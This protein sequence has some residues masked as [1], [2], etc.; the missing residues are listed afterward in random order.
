MGQERRKN[1]TPQFEPKDAVR[2]LLRHH[3]II[4]AFVGVFLLGA[5]IEH[6]LF[7][8]FRARAT[9]YIDRSDT[10]VQNVSQRLQGAVGIS[11]SNNNS[12]DTEKY[13]RYMQSYDFY[14]SVVQDVKEAG[15]TNQFV[16]N[17]QRMGSLKDLFRANPVPKITSGTKW[18]SEARVRNDFNLY[19]GDALQSWTSYSPIGMDGIAVFVSSPEKELS[20][21]LADLI[22]RTGLIWISKNELRQLDS[23][24]VYLN[25]RIHDSEA[26]IRQLEGNLVGFKKRNKILSLNGA[27]GPWS[28]NPLE[29]ALRVSKAQLEE[30]ERLVGSY[31]Q[32]LDQQRAEVADVMRENKREALDDTQYKTQI[33]QRVAEIQSQNEVLR[34]RIES[35]QSQIND[36]MK[37]GSF[38]LEQEAYEFQKKFEL[39]YNLYQDLMKE[40]FRVELQKISIQNRMRNITKA[41][42]SEVTRAVPLSKKLLF[43]FLVAILLSA[44]LAYLIE[45]FFPVIRGSKDLTD[46]G[47][48]YLGGV[49]DFSWRQRA[50]MTNFFHRLNS[51]TIP[52]FRFDID[53]AHL[54]GLEMVRSKILHQL[55]RSQKDKAVIAFI[56]ASIGDGRTFVATNCA[57]ALASVGRK[58]LLIDTDLRH[59]GCSRV[60]NLDGIRG[61]AEVVAQPSLFP[62]V[63]TKEVLPNLDI[64]PAGDQVDNPTEFFL[65]P[66][67]FKLIEELSAQYDLVILDTPP[68]LLVPETF[69]IEKAADFLVLVAAYNR[70]RVEDVTRTCETLLEFG[71]R[72]HK[73]LAILNRYN[74]RHDYLVMAP[75]AS[76]HSGYGSDKNSRNA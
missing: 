19:L 44:A 58:T 13:I 75:T 46:M 68:S 18:K 15:L 21:S 65:R 10:V 9:I 42:Y 61:L 45:L 73:N 56:G 63:V 62:E 3:R 52:V 50:R 67:F 40:K 34:A 60:F 69:E 2:F 33:A 14:L 11:D 53:S 27:T 64:L 1:R 54:S 71:S 16:A 6:Q 59:S 12:S 30:N 5:V 7:P 51:K 49:Q 4:L 55:A 72:G 35:F 32:K 74:I 38:G 37:G 31:Q 23:A 20:R 26:K 28:R 39:Q 29:D 57:A 47:F 8:V 25:G 24:V 76:Y 43:S 70:T 41:E 48:T 36:T 66:A 22:A 17:I